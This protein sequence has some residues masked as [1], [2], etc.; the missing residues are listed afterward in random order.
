M[1]GRRGVVVTPIE[2]QFETDC[3]ECGF[4]I[5]R[6][7]LIEMASDGFWRHSRCPVLAPVCTECWIEKPCGCEDG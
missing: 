5:R 2:T 3:V 7:Q 1:A 4:V 6:G